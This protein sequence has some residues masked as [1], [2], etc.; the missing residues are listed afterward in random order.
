MFFFSVFFLFVDFS[1][2]ELPRSANVATCLFPG[3]FFISVLFSQFQHHHDNVDARI[4]Q[5]HSST[6]QLFGCSTAAL[7]MPSNCAWGTCGTWFFRCKLVDLMYTLSNRC[8][9]LREE[10]KS[11]DNI[12]LWAA[13]S[14]WSYFLFSNFTFTES[15]GY[16]QWSLWALQYFRKEM[17]I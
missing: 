12:I 8:M 16:S 11:T 5:R 6:L 3:P 17:S 4:L 1:P 7:K 9:C 14:F 13:W 2:T 10:N 15:Q